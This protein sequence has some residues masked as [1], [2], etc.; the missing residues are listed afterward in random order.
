MP[1]GAERPCGV[2]ADLIGRPET[3]LSARC[4]SGGL[5]ARGAAVSRIVEARQDGPLAPLATYPGRDLP[6]VRVRGLTLRTALINTL[7]ASCDPCDQSVLKDQNTS[8][9]A[10][11]ASIELRF[12]S[13]E[14][15]C[16][17]V[18]RDAGADRE[19]AAGLVRPGW[20]SGPSL[21][22]RHRAAPERGCCDA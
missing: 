16:S 22:G 9:P 5:V 13:P 18:Q 19:L 6:I 10:R 11:K 17:A 15:E 8:A 12:P 3:C 2:P 1:V 21:P 4:L 14:I 7:G 20:G